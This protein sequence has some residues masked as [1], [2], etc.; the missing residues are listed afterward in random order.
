MKF[1]IC[2]T[3]RLLHEPVLNLAPVCDT[4]G[5]ITRRVRYW[6]Q[7]EQGSISIC[8]GNGLRHIARFVHLRTAFNSDPVGGVMLMSNNYYYSR[9]QSQWESMSCRVSPS[10]HP[11]HR[12]KKC[13]IPKFVPDAS[14]P[15]RCIQ[16]HQGKPWTKPIVR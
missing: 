3:A 6:K 9:S 14:R 16:Y 15:K 7:A 4:E 13:Q 12:S 8:T 1:A 11:L 5:F 10:Q 2:F